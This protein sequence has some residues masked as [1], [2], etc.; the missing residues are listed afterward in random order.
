MPLNTTT[1]NRVVAP[2]A[3]FLKENLGWHG[4]WKVELELRIGQNIECTTEEVRQALD[5]LVTQGEAHRLDGAYMDAIK[6]NPK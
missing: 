1:E 4:V 5:L 3:R 2:V 6:L